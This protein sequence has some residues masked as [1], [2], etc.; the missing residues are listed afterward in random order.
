M[1]KSLIILFILLFS[2]ALLLSEESNFVGKQKV[3]VKELYHQGK[4][5]DFIA[6][7]VR[8]QSFYN[9]EAID[10]C[11]YSA[12][13]LGGQHNTVINYCNPNLEKEKMKLPAALLVSAS[14]LKLKN[15]EKSFEALKDFSYEGT[16]E[17]Y[18][19]DLFKGRMNPLVFK[20][21]IETIKIE[22]SA[23]DPFLKDDYNFTAMRKELLAGENITVRSNAGAAVMSAIV[24]GA[25]QIYSG[26]F[27]AGVL[28]FLSVAATMAGG[29]YCHKKNE[30]GS[31]YTLFFF[32]G[33]FYAGNIYGAYNASLK[34]NNSAFKTWKESAGF[35][36]ELFNPEKYCPVERVFR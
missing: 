27:S 5:F 24:P 14:Y 31:A 28:S 19:F 13:Y 23:A 20:N 3:F 21:D 11:I 29:I 25:G 30:K 15:K 1:K 34:A 33:L 7:A 22:I 35:N 6:E 18:R 36:G 9:H 16:E 12:Y 8:L 2:P 4:Y 26:F 17:K 10:Y 32:S